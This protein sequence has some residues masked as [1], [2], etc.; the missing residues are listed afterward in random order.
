MKWVL[1]VGLQ[2]WSKGDL[3]VLLL[4]L[5]SVLPFDR[6]LKEETIYQSEGRDLNKSPESEK[7]RVQESSIWYVLI[8][9]SKANVS[10]TEV[11]QLLC[12]RQ[13]I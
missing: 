6:T 3:L 12:R 2:A 7:W 11:V 1:E 10:F 4:M 9:F 5:W 13:E 8:Y